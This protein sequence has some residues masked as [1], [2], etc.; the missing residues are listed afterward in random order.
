MS[1]VIFLIKNGVIKK[2][3]HEIHTSRFGE[4]FN[5]YTTT[6]ST[7]VCLVQ[8]NHFTNTVEPP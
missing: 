2:I 8:I 7:S 5:H 1:H 4:L 3:E 6:V